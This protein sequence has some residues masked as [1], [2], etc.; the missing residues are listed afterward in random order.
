[1][2]LL[3]IRDK[4]INNIPNHSPLPQGSSVVIQFF[5]NKNFLPIDGEDRG[6][7]EKELTTPL[8]LALSRKGRGDEGKRMTLTAPLT[9]IIFHWWRKKKG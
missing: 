8:I 5:T 1:V 9:L 3:V 7:G 2:K 6:G 4:K